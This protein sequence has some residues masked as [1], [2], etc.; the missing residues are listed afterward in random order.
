MYRSPCT[1]PVSGPSTVAQKDGDLEQFAKGE[2]PSAD[3]VTGEGTLAPP[4][5]SGSLP[6]VL[7]GLPMGAGPV[8]SDT[9]LRVIVVVGTP[10]I[11]PNV[12]RTRL[13]I[14]TFSWLGLDPWT[15]VTVTPL[16]VLS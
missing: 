2:D 11:A 10:I 16:A 8:K 1:L 7:Q 12:F 9:A 15:A 3:P 4:P 6:K 14:V 13:E 5:A